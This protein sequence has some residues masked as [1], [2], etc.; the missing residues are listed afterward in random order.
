[1]NDTPVGFKVELRGVRPGAGQVFLRGPDLERTRPAPAGAFKVERSALVSRTRPW[2][3]QRS[4]QPQIG[5]TAVFSL[6]HRTQGA[7]ATHC[8]RTCLT[9]RLIFYFVLLGDLVAGPQGSIPGPGE[10]LLR[11][12]WSPGENQK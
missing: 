8:R 5:A 10:G 6:A 4:D 7:P 2:R 12:F 11:G 3:Q 1:M 9:S